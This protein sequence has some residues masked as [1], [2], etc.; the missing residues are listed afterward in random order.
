M[1]AAAAVAPVT[2]PRP[3]RGAAARRA[4]A[5]VLFLGGL[6][7]LGILIGGPAHA[8]DRPPS[9]PDATG[10]ATG[11]DPAALPA[12]AV[13]GALPGAGTGTPPAPGAPALGATAQGTL[14]DATVPGLTAPD[15]APHDATVPGTAAHDVTVPDPTVPDPTVPGLTTPDLAPHDVTVAGV[16][17]LGAVQDAG[18]G[19]P[20]R[21]EWPGVPADG[22]VP[23]TPPAPDVLPGTHQAAQG[24]PAGHSVPVTAPPG[25]PGPGATTARTPATTAA[26]AL[27]AWQGWAFGHAVID[28]RT[29]QDGHHGRDR[30]ADAVIA[31]PLPFAP[32]PCPGGAAR[33]SAAG[34]GGTPRAGE[35]HAVTSAVAAHPGPVRGAALPATAASVQDRPHNILEFPG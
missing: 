25:A 11:A 5:V 28:A 22:A 16:T 20:G 29:A 15:L 9:R 35:Q 34:D 17:V 1:T 18:A 33:Q 8:A 12:A 14:Q 6:L 24:S 4:L 30:R 31:A 23:V 3:A 32:G 7:A 19:L 27:C 21:P 13:S 2:A 26:P 10:T